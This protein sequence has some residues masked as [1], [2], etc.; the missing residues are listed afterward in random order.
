VRLDFLLP[1]GVR[2]CSDLLLV[3]QASVRERELAIRT[4]HDSAP[5]AD[6]LVRQFLT[7]VFLLSLVLA[8]VSGPRSVLGRSGV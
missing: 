6:R 1:G 7:E 8:A 5:H 2:E 4:A 3:I